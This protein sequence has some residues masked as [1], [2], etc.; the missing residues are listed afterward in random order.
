MVNVRIPGIIGSLVTIGLT[1]PIIW[2]LAWGYSN[3]ECTG[4]LV[5]LII[6]SVLDLVLLTLASIGIINKRKQRGNITSSENVIEES[7]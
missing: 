3:F 7:D 1:V 2:F 4:V 6:I 5:V